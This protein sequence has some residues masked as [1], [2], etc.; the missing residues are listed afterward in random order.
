MGFFK[1]FW[2]AVKRYEICFGVN[3]DFTPKSP[4][5]SRCGYNIQRIVPKK[6]KSRKQRKGYSGKGN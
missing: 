3:H 1:C 4:I 5:C 2:N 6:K